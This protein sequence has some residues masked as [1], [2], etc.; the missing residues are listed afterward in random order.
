MSKW[1]ARGCVSTLSKPWQD[2]ADG[3]STAFPR[4]HAGEKAQEE[5]EEGEE[6]EEERWEAQ[7][8]EEQKEQKG[9]GAP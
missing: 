6:K 7:A 4:G 8:Q 2:Y 9:A 3:P 1:W 5:G